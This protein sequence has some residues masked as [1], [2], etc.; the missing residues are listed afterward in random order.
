MAKEEKKTENESV[1]TIG[2]PGNKTGKPATA[3]KDKEEG[4][5][6]TKKPKPVKG[7]KFDLN[8]DKCFKY[9]F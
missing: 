3:E 5:G 4:K 9:V 6:K 1:E 7:S 8:I 2:G